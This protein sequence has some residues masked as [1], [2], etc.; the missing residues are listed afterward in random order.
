MDLA[1][2]FQIEDPEVFI[3]WNIREARLLD[4]LPTPPTSVTSGYYCISCTSLGGLRHELGFHFRPRRKGRL[5]ELEFFR[6]S[7]PNLESSFEEFERHL[8]AT[9]GEPTEQFEGDQNLPGYTWKLG[10]AQI[11]HYVFDRFGPEEHVRIRRS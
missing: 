5:K 3:P 7:Y 8:R 6:T 2:G 4:L 11:Q 10:P 9:F 1:E